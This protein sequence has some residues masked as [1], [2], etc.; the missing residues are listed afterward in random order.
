MEAM[1][2]TLEGLLHE[3]GL[4]EEDFTVDDNHIRRVGCRLRD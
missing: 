2:D 4:S 3:A 1:M